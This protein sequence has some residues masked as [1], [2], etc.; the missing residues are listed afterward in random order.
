MISYLLNTIISCV[1]RMIGIFV[2]L[3]FN[4]FYPLTY[5]PVFWNMTELSKPH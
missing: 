4:L 1:L 5:G 2:I 3:M